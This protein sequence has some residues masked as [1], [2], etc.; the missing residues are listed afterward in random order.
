MSGFQSSCVAPDTYSKEPIEVDTSSTKRA[1]EVVHCI[2][3]RIVLRH[4][5][6]EPG[7]RIS[8]VKLTPVE[9]LTDCVRSWS[10]TRARRH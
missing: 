5:L 3:E 10:R 8:S 7:E 4:E 9:G 2:L 6:D 1:V